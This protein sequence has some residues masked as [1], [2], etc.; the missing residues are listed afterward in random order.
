MEGE[1]IFDTAKELLDTV[2]KTFRDP[3][4]EDTWVFQITTMVQ[5][6]KTMD[7]H[8]QDF[9]IAVHGSGYVGTP[10]IYKFKQSLNK[11]LWEWLHNL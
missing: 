9:K 10:L 11:G 6:D 3:N 5:G 2:R 1:Q 7:E 4:E 8:V